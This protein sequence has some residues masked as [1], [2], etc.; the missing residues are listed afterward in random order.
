MKWNLEVLSNEEQPEQTQ[1][2]TNSLQHETNILNDA[3]QQDITQ[4]PP[5]AYQPPENLR[6]VSSHP[7]S[8]VIGDPRQGVRTRSN[9]NQM[10]AH[11]AF[12]SQIEPKNFKDAN[13]DSTLDLCH[14]RGT[15]SI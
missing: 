11:C 6:E 8:N 5:V 4:S 12:V 9:L 3:V 14:A 15:C 2:E 10:I 13:M 1:Q 7:L